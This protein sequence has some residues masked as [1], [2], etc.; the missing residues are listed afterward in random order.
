[1]KELTLGEIKKV[2]GGFVPFAVQVAVYIVGQ[3]F[4]IYGTYRMA[5]SVK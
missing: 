1:M 5:N 2:N 3:G 4:S